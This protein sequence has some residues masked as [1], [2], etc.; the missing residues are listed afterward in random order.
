ML[1][2]P[3]MK[4]VFMDLYADTTPFLHGHAHMGMAM[5]SRNILK[6]IMPKLLEK[7]NEFEGFSVM[8]I[9]YSLGTRRCSLIFFLVL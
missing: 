6:K 2:A 4:D 3:K 1:P 9:G 7:L 8:V 5:G